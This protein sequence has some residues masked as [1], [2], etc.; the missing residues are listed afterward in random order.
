MS[1]TE[2][3]YDVIRRQGVTRRSFTKFCSLTSASMGWARAVGNDAFC[4]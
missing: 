2:T 4:G 3:F 1:A